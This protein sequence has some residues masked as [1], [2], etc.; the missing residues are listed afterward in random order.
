MAARADLR[1][2]VATATQFDRQLAAIKFPAAIG[3][4]ARD[5]I[6]ANQARGQVITRQA[7]AKTLARMRALNAQHA[8]AD[9][10]VEVQVKRI[11]QALHLPAASNS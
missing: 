8:A 7:R 6:R 5:L 9:A 11:R 1:A 4:L 10:A 3:A 2:E